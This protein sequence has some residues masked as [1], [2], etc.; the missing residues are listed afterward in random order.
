MPRDSGWYQRLAVHPSKIADY[1]MS[2]S[3]EDGRHKQRILTAH[4]FTDSRPDVLIDA[5]FWHATTA[6]EIS[7]TSTSHGRKWVLRGR[8][9]CPDGH[10][11]DRADCLVRR[12]GRAE[13][14]AGNGVSCTTGATMKEHERVV[15][16]HDLP[17]AG[18]VDGD[19]G[20]IV[21]V[22]Q[23]GAAYEV[24]FMTLDGETIAV[25]TLPAGAV[26]RIRPTEVAHARD[27]G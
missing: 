3:H 6:V 7:D 24:E 26:R 27:V 14:S 9:Q 17:E 4:G 19:L 21:A 20:T 1:L 13:R 5:L 11:P 15:L 10:Q 12:P 22:Y 23:D 8:L 25:S 2:Q 16:T 18:L